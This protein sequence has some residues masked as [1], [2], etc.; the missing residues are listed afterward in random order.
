MDQRVMARGAI[1]EMHDTL[2]MIRRHT[3][4]DSLNE[5]VNDPSVWRWVHGAAEGRLDLSAVVAD[6][7][8]VLL[9]GEHGGVLFVRHQPGLY[10]AHTQVLPAGRGSWAIRM[11]RAALH[12]MFTHTDAVEI[13]TRVPKGN[14]GARA[15]AKAIGGTLE[16]T[17]PI[18][19]MMDGVIV[20]AGIYS[21]KIQDWM[22]SA[23]GLEERGHW[24]H[25]H[26][27]AEYSRLGK[28]EASHPDDDNHD[29]YV[30]A[31]VEMILGGQ[32]DKGVIFY[33]R[34]AVMAGYAPV[35]I[36]TRSPLTID[37]R[38]A[39]ICVGGEDFW[40]MSCQ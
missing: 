31:A 13:M 18:G 6:P 30:G 9:M 37:I 25:D 34:W 38:D 24:F 5:V 8:N 29:R 11:V 27:E 2:S 10:E 7:A 21:L 22:R 14:L 15:L 23:G 32:P 1:S 19:W 28:I 3:T 12:W 33:N 36:V 16:F 40:V 20:P 4:A 39:L 26:L 17:S 35:S